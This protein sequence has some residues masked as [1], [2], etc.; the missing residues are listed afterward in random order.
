MNVVNS[1]SGLEFNYEYSVNKFNRPTENSNIVYD[2]S[3]V[4][5]DSLQTINIFKKYKVSSRGK[6][7]YLGKVEIQFD[8]SDF[9]FH[10]YT[11][12][13]FI[14]HFFNL[15]NG[16]LNSKNKLPLK[17]SVDY[18]D[19]KVINFNLTK[20]QKINALLTISDEQINFK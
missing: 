16:K 19:G 9:V 11:F 17:F 7:K 5:L 12:K 13:L 4:H 3:T 1:D 8:N 18:N 10:E 15:E 14:H 2:S 6:K 20:K